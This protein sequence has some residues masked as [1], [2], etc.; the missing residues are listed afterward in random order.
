VVKADEA[1]AL[2][3]ERGT[4]GWELYARHHRAQAL[5]A[6]GGREAA[7]AAVEELER[8]LELVAITGAQAFEPRLRR[9][10]R[11]SALLPR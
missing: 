7:D 3:C 8:A 6:A 9:D 4:K 5:L 2:A 1:V 11:R 10:L